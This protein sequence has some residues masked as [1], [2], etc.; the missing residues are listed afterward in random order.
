MPTQDHDVSPGEFVNLVDEFSMEA[1]KGY[2]LENA[3]PN[4]L[5]YAELAAPPTD[6]KQGSHALG[7]G[8]SQSIEYDGTTP[9]YAWVRS[10]ELGASFVVTEEE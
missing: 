2:R 4:V 7:P 3:G 5:R 9:W 10:R 6:V 1:D 8:R